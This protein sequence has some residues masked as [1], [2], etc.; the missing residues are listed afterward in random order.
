MV[1]GLAS[2]E[3]FD[4][5]Q[6]RT[7]YLWIATNN[8]LQRFDGIAYKTFRHQKNNEQSLASNIIIKLLI[9]AKDNLWVVS[10]AG[11]VGLFDKN[12]FVYKPVPI[13]VR[14]KPVG[15]GERRL[16]TDEFGNV[17][18]SIRGSD[19]L[20]YDSQK[21]S[22]VSIAG[23]IPVKKEWGFTSMSQ[24]PGTQ[25]YWLGLETGG[26]VI[27]NRKTGSLSYTGNNV[28]Q[29][30]AIEL[31]GPKSDFAY[32][33]FD[34]QGRVWFHQ[35]GGGFPY[36]MQYDP[37]RKNDPLKKY[38]FI[39]ALKSY[40]ELRGV[41]QQKSGQIWVYGYKLM[42]FFNEAEG[43]FE[44]IPNDHRNGQ[45]IN[46]EGITTLYEDRE[47]NIWVG[48][49]NNGL[50][51]FN[52]SL[53]FF[54][55]IHH[56]KR[57]KD[58][59]GEGGVM[60]FV[61]TRNGSLL[62]GTWEDGPFRY[63]SALKNIPLRFPDSAKIGFPYL[64]SM[65]ASA[66]SN[67]IWMGA[68]PGLYLY[69]QIKN[70]ILYRN[71][72]ELKSHTIRQVA[73]DRYGNLW[74]GMHGIGVY[75][76]IDPKNRKRDSIVKVPEV[77]DAMINQVVID[78]TGLVWIASGNN[79]L[80]ALDSRSG[81]L[82]KQ[83][84]TGGS[85]EGNMIGN[86][87]MAL[88]DY[89]DSLMLISTISNLFFYSRSTG[90]MAELWLPES[91]MGNINTVQKDDEGF[92]WVGTTNALYRVHPEKKAIVLFNR[93]DG[94]TNDRFEI[95]ASYRMK[96]GRLLFGTSNSFIAFSPK[97][98]RLSDVANPI[99]FTGIQIGKTELRVDSVTALDGL[100]LGYKDNSLNI[101]F[102][103]LVYASPSLIQYKLQGID[104][105]WRT[106]DKEARAT[107]PFLPPGRY[108]LLLRTVNAEGIPNEKPT[109]LRIRIKPPFYQT[110][111]F[112][113]L[114]GIA[115][116]FQLYWLDK[117]RNLR[118]KTLQK[119]RTDV[120]DGLHKEVNEALNNINILSE[121]AR[122]KSDKEP[123]KA[124][125]YLEQIH[126][127]SH[128]MIIAMDDM[129]WSLNPENDS[130]DK[131]ISRIKEYADALMQRHPVNIELLIDKNVAKLQLNMKLRHEAFLLFKEGLRSLVEAGT[132]VCIVH[133]SL[134]KAK[135]LFTIE[136]TNEGC[137]MQ[138]L[139]NLLHR[140]DM[141]AR[142]VALGA[143]LDVQLHK[144]R[145]MFLL[146]LPLGY[147]S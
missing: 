32:S 4:V 50:Y 42:A 109:S 145:S 69:D 133:L 111:W 94:M 25:K 41:M 76:W 102:S 132:A 123:Q 19:V 20:R 10:N 88:L 39:T 23:F 58:G 74:L 53:Q 121:I 14:S 1:N 62:T 120:S 46:Y 9:D 134:E 138:Q 84:Q 105:E 97:A 78:R 101:A 6:D 57:S 95:S 140:R 35:W 80:F 93:L 18:L 110:W 87:V 73:E 47:K 66:D 30:Q 126:T 60:S 79:G 65:C 106:A 136:F 115:V 22:F 61:E 28:E 142:L 16:I 55:N 34:K 103:P 135:L 48:T 82:V 45:G 7:G 117:Q 24:Q 107:F 83:W 49:E 38:E 100:T 96:D 91:F 85:A 56:S 89:N 141:E 119:V 21:G 108:T 3:V 104:E 98:I 99:V 64:W 5:A 8:G 72:L 137:D 37:G 125:D 27:Y 116:A 118:K 143:K 139:N 36:C 26:L 127:K 77:G 71:P 92:I 29:E 113:T 13:T 59:I 2:N 122:L 146:Q 63:T 147:K 40:H 86:S 43:S 31:A 131:T 11:Q 81:R 130:M 52:P 75:R 12:A 70:T 128:N 67:T 68:Q 17:F 44:I 90:K 51:R 112:Y 54:T 124:K 114:L 129:L 15:T 33:F 144:S